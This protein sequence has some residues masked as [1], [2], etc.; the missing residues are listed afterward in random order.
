MTAVARQYK[1][2]EADIRR[3]LNIQQTVI[4]LIMRQSLEKEK[5]E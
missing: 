1:N 3:Q 5:T 2:R 4:A